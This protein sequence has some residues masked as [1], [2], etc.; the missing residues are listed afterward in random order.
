M[1]STSVNISKLAH[2]KLLTKK[3]IYGG[4]AKPNKKK[5]HIAANEAWRS[6]I[7]CCVVCIIFVCHLA[8][9][10]YNTMF[11]YIYI[12]IVTSFVLE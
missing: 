1:S 2:R 12:Y 5:T 7:T 9:N 3:T 11:N 6:D 10:A 4:F 8:H